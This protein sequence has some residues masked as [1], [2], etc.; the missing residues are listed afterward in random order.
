MTKELSIA[1][2]KILTN[3]RKGNATHENEVYIA[4]LTLSWDLT[5]SGQKRD[6]IQALYTVLADDGYIK[7]DTPASDYIITPKGTLFNELGGYG[8][9]FAK[10]E[11]EEKRLRDIQSNAEAS[12]RNIFFLTLVVALGTFVMAIYSAIQI[13]QF[14][15]SCGCD[16]C[17][18]N[19]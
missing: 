16:Y 13:Y 4:N 11:A 7:R 12:A 10:K 14:W 2:D 1:L 18:C 8:Q 17:S 9:A 15:V 5:N 19:G 6:V 3:Y